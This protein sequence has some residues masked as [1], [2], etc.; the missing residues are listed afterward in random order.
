MEFI[1]TGQFAAPLSTFPDEEAY[2]DLQVSLIQRP[3]QGDLIQGGG[4]IR[5]L[6]FAA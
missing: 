5:K 1:E 4:G 6:R 3:E 2:L